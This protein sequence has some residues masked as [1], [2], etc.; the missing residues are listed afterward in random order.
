MEFETEFE[1]EFEMEFEN[2]ELNVL[3]RTGSVNSNILY[4]YRQM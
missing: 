3:L 4:D 1:M 2:R